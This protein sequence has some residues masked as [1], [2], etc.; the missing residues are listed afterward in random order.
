MFGNVERQK[1]SLYWMSC[2]ILI[3]WMERALCDEE[4]LSKARVI[5]DLERSTLME[6]VSCTQK[7]RAMWLRESDKCK[8]LPWSGQFEQKK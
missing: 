1:K 6:E 7:S 8:F 5:S 3:F 2:K 4:K